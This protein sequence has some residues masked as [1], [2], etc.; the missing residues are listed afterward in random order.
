L[1]RALGGFAEPVFLLN[2]N[3]TIDVAGTP[4]TAFTVDAYGRVTFTTAPASGALLTWSGAFYWPV[5]FDDDTTEFSQFVFNLYE[6]KAL[7][8]TSEKLP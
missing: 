6:V 5:R 3:P 8:F 2:G 4:T 1:V 7:K